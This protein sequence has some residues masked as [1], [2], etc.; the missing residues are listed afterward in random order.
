MQRGEEKAQVMVVEVMKWR[1]EFAK[2]KKYVVGWKGLT[3]EYPFPY[4]YYS[5]YP[6]EEKERDP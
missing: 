3:Y 2:R 6:W 1:R 5:Y 4:P